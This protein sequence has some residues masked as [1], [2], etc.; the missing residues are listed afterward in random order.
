MKR[1]LYILPAIAILAACNKETAPVPADSDEPVIRTISLSVDADNG[2]SKATYDDENDFAAMWEE[3]DQILALKGMHSQSNTATDYASKLDMIS[4]Y[5]GK[6]A[7]FSSDEFNTSTDSEDSAYWYFAY[8]A[9]ASAMSASVTRSGTIFNF[10]YAYSNSVSISIPGNQD[11]KKWIPYMFAATEKLTDDDSKSVEFQTLS[12]CLA[13]KIVPAEE[14]NNL[15][16]KIQSI[17]IQSENNNLYGRFTKTVNDN[18]TKIELAAADFVG[19]G[20]QIVAEFNADPLPEYRFN[21]PAG[22]DLGQITVTVVDD[23]NRS[24][25]R[26]TASNK[27]VNP[28]HK[29]NL[30]FKWETEEHFNPVTVTIKNVAAN[31]SY[32][33]YLAE[34]LTQANIMENRLKVFC[35]ADLDVDGKV[36][37]KSF[38]FSLD[39]GLPVLVSNQE[40]FAHTFD[41]LSLDEHSVVAIATV[42]GKEFRSEPQSFYI[43]GLPFS[44]DLNNSNERGFWSPS[45]LKWAN[46]G[47]QLGDVSIGEG[48]DELYLNNIYIPAIPAEINFDASIS[49]SLKRAGSQGNPR[50]TITANIGDKQESR[51]T[52]NSYT[53]F[54]AW[55]DFSMNLS[56]KFTATQVTPVKFTKSGNSASCAVVKVVTIKYR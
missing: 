9:D 19:E 44:G 1:S 17:T 45:N 10:K 35:S 8:P 37:S 5:G 49:G 46:G 34:N 14:D 25:T 22:V 32:S 6:E 3:G 21:I 39:G 2:A 7:K 43:T 29:R 55:E 24:V 13:I 52:S 16:E 27:A 26:R 48:T 42:N 41:N 51:Q 4:E 36:N 23:Q 15:P 12:A 47:C 18:D 30:K 53:V 54:N 50:V 56:G 38:A 28:G 31:S 40:V 33:Y 20:N 11:G